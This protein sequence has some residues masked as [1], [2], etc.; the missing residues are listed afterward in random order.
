MFYILTITWFLLTFAVVSGFESVWAKLVIHSKTTVEIKLTGYDGLAESSIFEGNLTANSDHEINTTY[1][2]LALLTFA[3]GQ[4]Y[5]VIIRDETFT[6]MIA[7]PGEP[8]SFTGSDTNAFFYKSLSGGE[9]ILGQ[10]DFALLMIQAKHLLESSH[11]IHT[12]KE[13]TIKK[14]EF[15][16]FV[17]KHYKSLKHSDMIK[18]LIAQ[19]FMM[20]EYVDYHA[21]G[22]PA[23]DIRFKY[24]K[25]VLSGV[26]S[27]LETLQSYIPKQEILNY[28]VSLYYKRSMVTLASL[29][30]DN[31]RDVAYCSGNENET[32]SLSGD[33]IIVEAGSSEE[34]K[35]AD[36]KGNKI[37]AFVS[38]E[39]PVSMVETVVKARELAVKKEKMPVIVA[40]LQRLS[41]KHLTIARMVSNG[42]VLFIDDEK[43]RKDNLAKKIKLPLF[44]QISDDSILE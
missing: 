18:R 40:P 5:P 28:C 16:E 32:F 15:H 34:R 24:Q 1:R 19:Y 23:D 14:K 36:F 9:P 25:A 6:V 26:G 42:N 37:I 21:E 44:V 12:V 33:I 31:F 11:L 4:R 17:R 29:I 7:D 10:Y 39:C 2:G 35:L 41:S 43:W 27:W 20:H 30:I 38:D 22:A 13:L 8:P 3:G